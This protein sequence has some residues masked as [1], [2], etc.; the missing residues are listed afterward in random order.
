MCSRI[1]ASFRSISLV[2]HVVAGV[3][4]AGV[5]GGHHAAKYAALPNVEIAAIFDIDA[6][7]AAALARRVGARAY[8]DID[9]FLEN[10]DAVTV[11][12]PASAHFGIAR[13]GL[14][15]GRHVLIEKPI[16]LRLEDADRLIALASAGDL[17]LQVG[18]QERFV[19]EAFGI[20]SRSKP[21]MSVRCVRAGPP[22][23]R[24]D[25]VSVAFD[26]MVHD[27]DLIRRLDLGAP[28]AI[29]AAGG[30]DALE[31]EIICERGTIVAMEASRLAPVRDRRMRLVYD[32]GLIEIDFVKRTVENTTPSPLTASFDD[33]C[34]H[35]PLADPLGYGVACFIDAVRGLAPPPITGEEAR[36][37]LEWA[38]MIEAARGGYASTTPVRATAGGRTRQRAM[39]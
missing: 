34:P 31:A 17:V 36:A 21:P 11:A 13:R 14:E 24:G 30:A 19:F 39:A 35:P 18:H 26:L 6:D 3:A 28:V 20:L 10:I 7:K 8:T 23:G 12:A 15:R 29:A 5:F 33:A 32:D 16:A 1:I 2:K 27:I 9:E 25:D 4:G 38:L 37:A 22:T